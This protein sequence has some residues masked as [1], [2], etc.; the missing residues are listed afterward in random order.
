LQQ[1]AAEGIDWLEYGAEAFKKAKTENKPILLA[2][3]AVWCHWCHVQDR[4]TYSDPEVIRAINR[5]Y[6]PIRV[7]NDKRPDINR[8]YNMGG[9]PTT[10]FLTPE[11]DIITGGTYIPPDQMK[12]TLREVR[13]RYLRRKLTATTSSI[14]ET[15]EFS[16]TEIS[17]EIIDHVLDSMVANFDPVHGGFGDAPKFP[18]ADALELALTQYW[19]S[20]DKGLL[21]IVTKTL[22]RMAKGGIYDNIA[23][24]FFRYSTT[25]DWTIPHYEKMCEDNA[26]L[27]A[28]YL[29]AY[30]ATGREEYRKNVVEIVDYV[31]TTLSDQ[32]AGGFYGSQDA[33]EEYYK[34]SGSERTNAKPPYVDRTIYSNWNGLMIRAYLEA[35]PVLDDP[36]LMPFALKSIKRILDESYDPNVGVIHHYLSSGKP[37]LRGLLIDQISFGD[38]L[39]KAY[40]TTGNREYLEFAR[41]LIQQIDG[42]LLDKKNGGYYDFAATPDSPGYLNRVEKPLDENSLAAMLL[43][44]LYHFTRDERFHQRAKS[45]LEAVSGQY[46]K[47]GFMASTCAL[48]IDLF[49]NEPT[50]IVI[51]GRLVEPE[52]IR[53]LEASLRAY[54]P[55][56]LIIPLDPERD[57]ERL[58]SLG[59]TIDPPPRAYICVGKTCFPPVTEPEEIRQ[60]LSRNVRDNEGRENTR[61]T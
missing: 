26:R 30:Q 32:E 34:L 20:G 40:E 37:H 44:R 54:D 52:T 29:H 15:R 33:D 14:V 21:T 23:G 9:W 35:A 53:L 2:I 51:V 55:R 31:S 25:R 43:T 12:A 39:V 45:T 16:A 11:G 49:L 47:Y 6:V 13:E 19:Y 46:V 48:A 59:Y 8:R 50:L 42:T 17:H 56:K 28:V 4:T 3:S 61:Q 18:H 22:D 41:R 7:D 1:D 58:N 24:G 38:A 27:L 10:A 57:R 60:K 36:R 5:H